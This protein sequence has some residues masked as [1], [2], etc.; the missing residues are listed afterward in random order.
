MAARRDSV[1]K[2]ALRHFYQCR[3]SKLIMKP[4]LFPLFLELVSFNVHFYMRLKRTAY[5][6]PDIKC[7][8]EY[9]LFFYKRAR[10]ASSDREG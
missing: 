7:S 9:I 6:I 8:G 10:I 1:I 3:L 5:F 2:T 4:N